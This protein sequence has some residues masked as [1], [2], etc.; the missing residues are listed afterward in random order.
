MGDGLSPP[1]LAMR[2]GDHAPGTPDGVVFAGSFFPIPL[3]FNDRRQLTFNASLSGT[4]VSS[5]NDSGV[6]SGG[7]SAG[8]SLIAREGD[9]APDAGTGIVFGQLQF[10]SSHQTIALNNFGQTAFIGQLAG[11]G[12]TT[13]NDKAIWAQDRN[14]ILRL[15]IRE[16]DTLDVDNGPGSNLKTIGTLGVI[17][18]AGFFEH[19]FQ[20]NDLGQIAFPVIFTDGS[21]GLF[22]SNLIA[23]PEPR[24][25]LLLALAAAAV[26]FRRAKT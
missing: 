23:V 7:G 14:G 24:A 6:W 2:L 20:I 11:A 25:C 26:T 8:L 9:P 13:A 1:Q 17:N 19:H 5:A 10:D 16:G 3:L 21:Q 15:I 12:I 18:N 4:G 22:V